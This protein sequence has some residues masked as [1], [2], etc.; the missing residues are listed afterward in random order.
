MYVTLKKR[1]ASCPVTDGNFLEEQKLSLSLDLT[2]TSASPLPVALEGCPA[3]SRDLDQG[4]PE[5][6]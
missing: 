5:V 6:P 3:Q 2:H 1:H 4:P